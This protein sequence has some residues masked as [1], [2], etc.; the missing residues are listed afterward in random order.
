MEETQE[1]P[2]LE[3]TFC[4]S[5]ALAYLKAGQ[6]VTHEHWPEQT[7]IYLVAGSTFEVNREPLLSLVP[8]GTVITYNPHI[9][10]FCQG[11]ASAMTFTTGDLLS[12]EWRLYVEKN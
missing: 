2:L 5:T 7:F 10:L 1:L 4:F 9:D 12:E 11:T 3:G 8:A 6:R